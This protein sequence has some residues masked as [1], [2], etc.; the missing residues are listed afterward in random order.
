MIK[1]FGSLYAGHVDLGDLGL[2]ATAVNDR[3]FDNDHLSTIFNRVERI[4]K[5]M[6]DLDYHSF[7]M[8]EHHFQHEGNE[9]SP[10]LVLLYVHIAHITKTLKFG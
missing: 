8:A 4:A 2:G 5:V 1:H 3:R 9:V 7:W 10:N 6:D